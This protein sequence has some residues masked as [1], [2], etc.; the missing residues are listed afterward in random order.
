M[1]TDELV[2]HGEWLRRLARALVGD[3]AAD[4]VVQETY[5]VALRQGPRHEGPLGPWLA[6]VARNLAR[7]RIRGNARR[8]KREEGLVAVEA[9]AP[10]ELVARAMMQQK[11]AGIVLEL[12][13]PFRSTVLL[14][15]HEGLSAAEIARAQDVPA[16]T[17]RWRLKEAL[18][19]VRT[20]LDAEHGGERKQWVLLMTPLGA[21]APTTPAAAGAAG[22]KL[23]IGGIAVKSGM[24]IA[25][26]VAVVIALV[27]G[28][29]AAGLWGKGKAAK[30]TAADTVR[31][32]GAPVPPPPRAA[33]GP[34]GA[35]APSHGPPPLMRDDDPKGSLRVE[36]IVL[37]EG[38]RGVAGATVA[39]DASPPITLQTDSDGS[40][41]FEGLIPRDYR[42]E[43]TSGEGYAGP[44]RLRL[45]DKPE[46]VT[47]RLRKGGVVEV[48]VTDRNGGGP[49]E[50]AQVELRAALMWSG[51]T[52][53]DGVATLRGVGPTWAPVAVSAPGYAPA[54]VMMST[55][56]DPAV[57]ARVAV[58][59]G[60]GA[61]VSGRVVDDAGKPIGGARVTAA[62]AS[63]PFP[64]VDPRRDGVLSGADGTFTLPA[65]AAGTYRLTASDAA[66][67]AATSTPF[68]L[69]GQ[70][71]RSGFEL[72]MTAGGALAGVVVDDAGRPVAGV[73]VRVVTR[74]HVD[75]RPRRQAF[76]GDDG[77]F[78]IAGL[79]RRAVEV[80]AW[81]PTGAS[82]ILPADLAAKPAH[83]L[84]LVLAITGAITGVVVDPAGE[85]VGDAQVVADPEGNGTNSARAEWSVRG[86]QTIVTD[87]AGAFRFAGLPAGSYRV[88]AAHPA[89]P[90]QAL[91]QG[92]GVAARPGGAPLRITL[93]PDG[94]LTGKVAF[95]DG[96]TPPLFAVELDDG[97]AVPFATKDGSFT[98]DAPNGTVA[99]RISGPGFIPKRLEAKIADGKRTDLGTITVEAGRSV[100]GRVTDGA[101]KPV[102]GARVAA[103]TLL[104]GGGAELYMENES[105]NSRSTET[106]DAGRYEL[107][108]FPP[109]HLTVVG[110][111]EGV[112][113][114]ASVAIAASKDSAVV[115]LVLQ[116]TGSVEGKVTRGGQPLGDTVL[117][118][119]PIGAP[120]SNFFV[121]TG[122]DGSFALDAL[123]PGAYFIYPM[124]GGGG[125]R[126]KDMVLRTVDVTAGERA[127]IEIDATPGTAKLT[128]KVKTDTGEPVALAA[129]LTVQAKV[130][131]PTME[132]LRDGSFLPPSLRDGATVMIYMRQAMGGL[133]SIEEMR[134]GEFTSCVVPFPVGDEL[135]LAR[136]VAERLNE[137]PM[138]CVPVTVADAPVTVDVVVPKAWTEKAAP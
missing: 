55:A 60:R 37:D 39:I 122:A 75:W 42:I 136:Q 84:R 47:L 22:K 120:S 44:A 33:S 56:G 96:K 5:E 92:K 106:D 135:G 48:V 70:N 28:T 38:E 35:A 111:K 54:A 68:V 99:V 100:S 24:K 88:R 14:R 36:G 110:G 66:H 116:A 137:L 21:A 83:D 85:P 19:R 119:N 16:G 69:D 25:A 113:R 59:I 138:K 95:A 90:E 76:T 27:A 91:W 20:K 125:P 45:T 9:P 86:V 12:D 79:P 34:Q 102:A 62:S 23:I 127:R 49:V 104:S 89:A 81:H 80:V 15:F 118:A 97:W 10:D 114:S 82:P 61:A 6:G 1:G 18:D 53:A 78:A 30:S 131:A 58:T 126:P 105:I 41:V 11:V 72:V 13:E 63:E 65:V 7:M 8:E 40:F 130:D 129:V 132:A 43:A 67:A 93:S 4:D 128:L 112:G 124:I 115:D 71:P 52:G 123:T 103:G 109:R 74:G 17:V 26:L 94:G 101:G 117:I 50:G 29:R 73:D 87:S 31:D 64:V 3:A 32:P 46:P 121:V 77:R 2:A 107:T 133:M 51:V 134:A 57:P 98:L 108:G